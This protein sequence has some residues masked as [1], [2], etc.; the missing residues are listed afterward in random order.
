MREIKKKV[1]KEVKKKK[2]MKRIVFCLKRKRYRKAKGNRNG[3]QEIRKR[4]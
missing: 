2:K 3:D 4:K 1:N